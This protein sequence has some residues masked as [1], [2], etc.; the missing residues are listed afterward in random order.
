MEGVCDDC[1][2]KQN[3][4]F[5][6]HLAGVRTT[7]C[8]KCA[9]TAA[10]QLIAYIRGF[11]KDHRPDKTKRYGRKRPVRDPFGRNRCPGCESRLETWKRGESPYCSDQCRNTYGG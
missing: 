10:H 9:G 4:T 8:R 5:E 7:L 2:R 1:K 11:D 6:G 3:W